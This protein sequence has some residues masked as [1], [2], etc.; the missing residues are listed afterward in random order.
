VQ[1]SPT[2]PSGENYAIMHVL[3]VP[4]ALTSLKHTSG[5]EKCKKG[6]YMSAKYTK[7]PSVLNQGKSKVALV[8]ILSF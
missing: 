7:Y 4:L 6:Q 5:K 3:A 8:F 2:V 1:K